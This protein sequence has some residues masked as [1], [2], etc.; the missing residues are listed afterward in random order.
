MHVRMMDHLARVLAIVHRNIDAICLHR[1]LDCRCDCVYCFCDRE[2]IV[3][4][5][6]KDVR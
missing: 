5:D 6:I 3:S 1:P 2:P 4:L